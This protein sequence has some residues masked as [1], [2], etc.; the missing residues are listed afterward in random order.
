MK[1]STELTRLIAAKIKEI[2]PEL[3]EF[4]QNHPEYF[5]DKYSG[6]GQIAQVS[7]S[8]SYQT[9]NMQEIQDVTPSM[10]ICVGGIDCGQALNLFDTGTIE[11]FRWIE[12]RVV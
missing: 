1:N 5:S 11:S 10:F 6:N 7:L 4:M 9:D 8:L 12:G 2:E 3:T